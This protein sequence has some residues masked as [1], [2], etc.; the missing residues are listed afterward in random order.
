MD[1]KIA[2]PQI[3]KLTSFE[4]AHPVSRERVAWV[5]PQKAAE[6]SWLLASLDW[7]LLLS[8]DSNH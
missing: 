2:P 5:E 4:R 7:L 1:L 3:C 6:P 8:G